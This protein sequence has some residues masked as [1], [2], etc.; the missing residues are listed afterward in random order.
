MKNIKTDHN[1]LYKYTNLLKD[2]SILELGCGN[3]I[4]TKILSQFS[5]N[6]S[7]IDIDSKSIEYINKNCSNVNAYQ[8]DISK[9]FSFPDKSFQVIV[10]SLCLHYFIKDE[11]LKIITEIR[12]ILKPGSTL[13]ARV[14]SSDDIHYG[15]EGFT[16]IE[17]GL[18]NVKGHSKRF[19]KMEDIIGFFS[20]GWEIENIEKK[21]IDRYLY[22]KMVWEFVITK[23]EIHEQN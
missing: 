11:T 3:G 15:A 20:V 18:F 13:I 4:D 1:W 17:P 12:R 8:A 16:E 5:D 19:F 7:V 14:N 22:P 9:P 21:C 2:K 6:V 10:A 23:K